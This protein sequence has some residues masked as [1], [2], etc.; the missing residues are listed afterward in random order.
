[1]GS[2]NKGDSHLKDD[3][4]LIIARHANSAAGTSKPALGE[5]EGLEAETNQLIAS[6]QLYELPSER[7]SL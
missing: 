2:W 1:L 6:R 3:C 5:I 4:H 7:S